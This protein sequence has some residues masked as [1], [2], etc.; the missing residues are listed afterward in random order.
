MPKKLVS[1]LILEGLYEYQLR[2][3]IN[4]A[5]KK[6]HAECANFKVFGNNI[7]FQ[8][9]YLKK[10]YTLEDVEKIRNEKV[11]FYEEAGLRRKKCNVTWNSRRIASTN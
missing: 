5:A 4:R 1:P 9:A 10:Q 6:T 7:Y 3:S 11:R 2:F 8:K